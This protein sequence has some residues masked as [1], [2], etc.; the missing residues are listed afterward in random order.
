MVSEGNVFTSLGINPVYLVGQIVN[1]LLLLYLLRKFLY[2]PVLRKLEDRSKFIARGVEAA[3][4]NL[5]KQEEI[6]AQREKK[7]VEAQKEVEA[8]ISMAKTEALTL[9]EETI[10]QARAEAEK[11]M[12]KKSKEIEELLELKEKELQNKMVDLTTAVA[13]KVLEEY[14][15]KKTQDQLLETQL[16][17]IA[18]SKVG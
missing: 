5:A 18:Q 11:L 8:L 15:D 7:L 1:F 14:I 13:K 6:E 10:S 17:K 3:K 12:Q 16:K 4:E 9:R 2:K